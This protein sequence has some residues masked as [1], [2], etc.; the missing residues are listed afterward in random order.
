M[1]G[2]PV[3]GLSCHDIVDYVCVWMCIT[4]NVPVHA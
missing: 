3:N 1:P 2:M 4:I